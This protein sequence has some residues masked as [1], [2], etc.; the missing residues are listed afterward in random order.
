[1]LTPREK[2][3]LLQKILLKEDR[4]HD[5]ASSRTTSPIHYQQATLAPRCGVV[6]DLQQGW[7]GDGPAEVCCSCEVHGFVCLNLNVCTMNAGQ[8]TT[9]SF[10]QLQHL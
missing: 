1:M 9:S 5:A 2:S 10:F 3:P 8:C 4:T 7:V 6:S